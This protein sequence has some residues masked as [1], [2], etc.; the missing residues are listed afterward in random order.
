MAGG[1]IF[2]CEAQISSN[3][4]S[5]IPVGKPRTPLLHFLQFKCTTQ[6][7]IP[8]QKIG[9]Y[10]TITQLYSVS[11]GYFACNTPDILYIYPKGSMYGI[12][13]HIWLIFR[14]NVGKYTSPM[15]PMV[16]FHCFLWLFLLLTSYLQSFPRSRARTTMKFHTSPRTMRRRALFPWQLGGQMEMMMGYDGCIQSFFK[17]L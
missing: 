16:I 9:R 5:T 3:S 15:D 13:T 17:H 2:V 12:F 11:R 4:L 7:R 1:L 6:R 14:V 8:V 10:H